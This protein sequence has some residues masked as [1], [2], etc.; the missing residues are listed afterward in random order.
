VLLKR[1]RAGHRDAPMQRAFG[2]QISD[3]IIG[4]AVRDL[5]GLRAMRVEADEGADDRSDRLTTKRWRGIHERDS[6]STLRRFERGGHASDSSTDHTDI[7]L[8]RL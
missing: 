7:G 5:V 8:D 1:D 3:E 4:D 2:R 6:T